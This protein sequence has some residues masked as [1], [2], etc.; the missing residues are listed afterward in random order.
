MTCNGKKD[1]STEHSQCLCKLNPILQFLASKWA[2]EIITI[3]GNHEQFR[4]SEIEDH[5]RGISPT[6]LTRR[7]QE[8]VVEGIIQKNVFRETPP[9]IE[10]SLSQKGKLLWENL[11]PLLKFQILDH[12]E[13]LNQKINV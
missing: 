10:Y 8:M 3:I 6:T 11:Q 5:L 1:C 12:E 9:R 4:F 13:F 7:L 2:L